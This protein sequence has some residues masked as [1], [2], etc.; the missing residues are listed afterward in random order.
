MALKINISVAIGL[1]LKVKKV[2][3]LILTFLEVTGEKLVGGPPEEGQNGFHLRQFLG[4]LQNLRLNS[5]TEKF[6]IYKVWWERIPLKL[7]IL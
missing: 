2:W 3:G 1:E 7:I 6:D 4:N 5:T